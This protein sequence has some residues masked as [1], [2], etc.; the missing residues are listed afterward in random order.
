MSEF[1]CTPMNG[2]DFDKQGKVPSGPSGV[3]N[4]EEDGPFGEYRRTSSPNSVP[5][6]TETLL[7]GG[8]SGESDQGFSDDIH[9]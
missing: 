1:V 8:V 7:K 5:E 9:K 2:S 4:G 3:Y 6:L